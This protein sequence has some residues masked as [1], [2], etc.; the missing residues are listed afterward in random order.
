[1]ANVKHIYSGA[2]KPADVLGALTGIAG[3]HYSDTETGNVYIGNSNDVWI[4]VNDPVKIGLFTRLEVHSAPIS[5]SQAIPTPRGPRL[6]ID[7][8]NGDAYLSV[9]T[10][11][12]ASPT[13]EWRKISFIQ[14]I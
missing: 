11:G 12:P 14:D 9:A 1:M 5:A 2:G 13:W 3:H 7:E 6:W 10:G 4:K 8:R